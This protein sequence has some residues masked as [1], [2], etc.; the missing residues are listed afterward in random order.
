[1]TVFF[2]QMMV[3]FR[4]MMVFVAASWTCHVSTA[5]MKVSMSAN[6][7]RK[8]PVRSEQKMKKIKSY[9]VV[10]NVGLARS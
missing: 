9:Y 8:S 10:R 1:M 2:R 4:Q 6:P 3:F 5:E 7:R